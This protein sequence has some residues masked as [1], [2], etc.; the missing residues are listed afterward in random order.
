M[1][2]LVSS[3]QSSK[4]WEQLGEEA[5]GAFKN[6]GDWTNPASLLKLPLADSTIR[7]SLRKNPIIARSIVREV[8]ADD[9]VTLP[10][11]H[12]I[13]KGAWM[14][15]GAPGLHHD[16]RFYPK[17]E[18]YDPFRFAKKQDDGL[19][20]ADKEVLTEKASIYRKNQALVTTSDIFLSFGYGKHSWYVL[21]RYGGFLTDVIHVLMASSPGRWLAAHQLKLMLAY[22][23]MNYD[24]QH[25]ALRPVN[26]VLGDAII[27]SDTATMMVRRR[28]HT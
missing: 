16:G 6:G 27:P 26:F 3:D 10:S 9:G 25:M 15:A 14:C 17:P 24:I 7:E 20:E 4:F 1:L 11:G 19:T 12:F 5:T 22:V 18:Q 8:I 21:I 2:D 23:A 13:P 28:K